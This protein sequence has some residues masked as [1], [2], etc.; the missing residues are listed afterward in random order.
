MSDLLLHAERWAD[1]WGSNLW[2]ATWQGAIVLAVVWVVARFCTF[3]SPRV[4]CWMWRLACIKLL[5]ALVW[6]VPVNVPLLPAAPA[7]AQAQITDVGGTGK[8][9]VSVFRRPSLL[10]VDPAAQPATRQSFASEAKV[11]VSAIWLAGVLCA[12]AIAVRQWIAARRLVLLSV[13]VR[14]RSLR[15]LCRQQS[16]R[17]DMR[18][19]PE[20]RIS[21]AAPCPALVGILRPTIV[22]PHD[23]LTTFGATELGLMA[24]HELAHWK[25]RDLAWNW[26]LLVVRSVFFFHPLV[27]VMARGW[28]EAQESACDELVLARGIARPAEYGRLLLTLATRPHAWLRPSFAAAGVFGAFGNLERRI[29]AM[30]RVK[31]LSRNHL[32]AAASLLLVAAIVSVVPWR[33]V[34]QEAK[35]AGPPPAAA[36]G[37]EAE[38]K[39][40]D[41]AIRQ[42]SMNNLKRIMLGMHNYASENSKGKEAAFPPAFTAKDGKPLLSWRVAI[43]PYVDQKAL[44]ERFKLDEPWDSEHNKKLIAYMPEVY[45][46]RAS[47]LHDGRTVYLTPRGAG[48]AFPGEQGIQFK[49]M[50]DGTSNTIAAVEVDDE[51]AVVWTKPDDWK[52]DPDHPKTGLNDKYDGGFLA[53]VCDGS[54]RRVPNDVEAALLKAMFTAAGGEVINWP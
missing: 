13:P 31:P 52:F 27:W 10:E 45:L 11:L 36:K 2:R 23:V 18:R 37:D 24:G 33:L 19:L 14:E 47:K 20:L 16:R 6:A 12:V 17:L 43:L 8:G 40:L 35:K 25:R 32:V 50:T 54:V 49:Q 7:M 1:V 41:L 30:T 26:L 22:F 38:K 3:L 4:V 21:R 34:A 44:Y 29:L 51:H 48:T 46:S 39:S 42:E 5:V 28:S 9:L 53:A 15:S